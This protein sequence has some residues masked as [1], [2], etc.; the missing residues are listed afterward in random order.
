MAACEP[1]ACESEQTCLDGSCVAA[2]M[3][4]VDFCSG[5]GDPAAALR[6]RE[7]EILELLQTARRTA[8]L[9]CGEADGAELPPLRL[10]PGLMCSARVLAADL[11]VTGSMVLVDSE[12]RSS[13]ERMALA[14]YPAVSWGEIFGY[15][16]NAQA[17]WMAMLQAM[18]SCELLFDPQLPDVGVGC[19][20]GVCVLSLGRQ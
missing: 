2:V 19:A 20:S 12:G 13:V 8:P 7:E 3:P 16:P 17:S 5:V 15:G 4:E 1:G 9:P 10:D 11:D 18:P 14:G 6:A